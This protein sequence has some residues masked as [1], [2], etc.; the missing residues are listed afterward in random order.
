MREDEDF[1]TAVVPMSE[2]LLENLPLREI[3][4]DIW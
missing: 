1:V 2:K 3:S 4:I